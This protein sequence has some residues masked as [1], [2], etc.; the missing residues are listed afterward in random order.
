[1][2]KSVD[3]PHNDNRSDNRTTELS[4]ASGCN[5]SSTADG[6]GKWCKVAI[7]SSKSISTENPHRQ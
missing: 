2:A 4:S 5:S 6:Q 1:M 3:E 7:S